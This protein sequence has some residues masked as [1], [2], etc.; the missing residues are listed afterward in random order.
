MGVL[1]NKTAI[2]TGGG[3]GIG[4][5]I[6]KRYLGEGAHV[7]ICGRR[8]EKLIEAVESISEGKERISY[9]S[10]DITRE[11]DINRVVG[12]TVEKTERIDIL[13]NNAGIMRFKKLENSDP[14]LWDM[15][16]KTNTYAPWRFMV[17]VL[18]AMR[19]V[20]GGSIINISSIA[21]LKPFPG[22]GIYCM[23]KAALHM[24]T[25]VMAV[26]VAT[27]KIR[28]NAICPA[29]VENTELSLP[30][31][32]EEGAQK[33]YEEMRLLQPLKRNGKPRD[34]AD[35]A[36]FLASDQSSWI[37]GVLLSLD[38][39]RHLATNRPPAVLATDG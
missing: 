36:L 39:G 27:D 35:G 21:G 31:F 7:V 9:I 38:G 24:I 15:T 37:T 5:A 30:I 22:V 3:T 8:E 19:K 25:Q 29:V 4:L 32:G 28:I 12:F 26:E 14:D 16:L 1:D 18:P 17:A 13:V 10:A 23:S 2:V 34:I 20:G 11:E 6:A 33:Y